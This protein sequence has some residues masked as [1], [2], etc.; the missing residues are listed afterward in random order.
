MKTK[1]EYIESLAS[2][3]KEWSAQIDRLAAKAGNA[4]AHLKDQYIEELNEL[5]TRQHEASLKIKELE[6]AG[7]DAWETIRET[8]D[9]VWSELGSCVASVVSKFNDK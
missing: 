1:D 7:S 4:S 9:K 8:T 6:E 3:L 2:E 5:R